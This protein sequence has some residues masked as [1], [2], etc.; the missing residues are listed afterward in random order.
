MSRIGKQPIDLPSGVDVQVDGRKVSM[1]GPKG[2]LELE[3]NKGLRAEVDGKR[4]QVLPQEGREVE[5]SPLHG[6]NRALLQ[7]MVVGVTKGYSKQLEIHGTGYQAKLSGKQVELQIGFAHPVF[8]P[9][10]SNLSVEVPTPE[11]I[12]ISGI[13]KQAV[14]E[15]AAVI[16]RV[17][18]PEPY[19][20][21]GI[22]Y[23]DEV[24]RRKAGKT[25]GG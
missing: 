8:I 23:S 6:L 18:K 9:I 24:V 21:K 5:L 4:L 16:R 13:D 15:L 1:K 19:K 10:P 7:N 22:R 11:K 3:L 17:R 20:G 25:M 2:T 12:T 14:G